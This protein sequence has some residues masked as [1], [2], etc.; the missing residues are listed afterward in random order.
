VKIC[1][2]AADIPNTTFARTSMRLMFE[3]CNERLGGERD[4]VSLRS[5]SRTVHLRARS[6]F[7]PTPTP[8]YWSTALGATESRIIELQVPIIWTECHLGG[9]RPWFKCLTL[10]NGEVCGRRVAKLY[11]PCFECR[12][13][14]G[15]S[16]ASQRE[17]PLSR[18]WRRAQFVLSDT[19]CPFSPKCPSTLAIPQHCGAPRDAASRVR[20]QSN[21]SAR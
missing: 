5:G 16:Y 19:C 12:Q 2:S 21:T 4:S 6:S 8:S 13:C 20:S 9:R 7:L 11:G 3:S 1:L 17:I 14:M 10:H 15:L 18:A